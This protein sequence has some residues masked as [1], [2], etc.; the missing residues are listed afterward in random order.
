MAAAEQLAKEQAEAESLA[1]KEAEEKAGYD[2]ALPM[3]S[4]QERPMNLKIR[5]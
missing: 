4:W 3:I 2:T 1:A 5:K